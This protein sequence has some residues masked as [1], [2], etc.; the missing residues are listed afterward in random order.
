MKRNITVFTGTR[1]EYGILYWLLKDLKK[2]DFCNLQL[3]VSGTHLSQQHGSTI[4]EIINDGFHIDETVEMISATDDTA[5]IVKSMGVALVGFSQ[6]LTRLSPNLIII[7]GDRYEALAIAQSAML[8]KI[9]IA[10]LHGGELTEGALDDNIRHA[11]T[12]MST[13]HFTANQEYA[14]RVI[15]LGEAPQRV[16]CVGALSLEHLHREKVMDKEKLIESIS[17]PLN[18]PFLLVTYHAVTLAN[19]CPQTTTKALLEALEQFSQYQVILTYPNADSGGLKIIKLLEQYK[20]ANEER[21]FLIKSL[22]QKRYF[23][24]AKHASA[25]I[26]NSSSGI[27]EVP[28]LETP[29]VN[30][31]SRQ[32]SRLASSSV[33]HCKA[34]KDSIVNAITQVLSPSFKSKISRTTNPY[35][36]GDTSQKIIDALKE[37]NFSPQKAFYDQKE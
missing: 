32:K 6:S 7:L 16:H 11:I 9:P 8:M 13:L 20:N 29:T 19:E 21:V 35:G 28:S 18:K 24:A 33:L 25:V 5:S 17:F 12:K 30:I 14:R 3:L 2:S 34:D 27:I 22:G 1:A 4:N 31:G 10:H 36:Q 26:G 15:Q 23:S 37:F